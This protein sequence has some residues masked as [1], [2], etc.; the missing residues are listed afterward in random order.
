MAQQTVTELPSLLQHIF[1][2]H[3]LLCVQALVSVGR[4]GCRTCSLQ[5]LEVLVSVAALSRAP[6]LGDKVRVQMAFP[7]VEQLV[8]GKALIPKQSGAVIKC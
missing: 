7:Q 1:G 5:L 8:P 2:E 4:E 3:L 6:G